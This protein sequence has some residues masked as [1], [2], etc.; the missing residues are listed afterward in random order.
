MIEMSAIL[1]DVAEKA[2]VAVSTVSYVINKTGLHKVSQETQERIR[3][4]A[5]ELGYTPN[6]A[7]RI[8]NGGR[9]GMIGVIMPMQMPLI[10]SEVP[11]D[12]CA[13]LRSKGYQATVGVATTSTERRE[14]INDMISRKVEGMIFFN[15]EKE[16]DDYYGEYQIPILHF[17]G[18]DGE[19]RMALEEGQNL[20]MR[21]L[22]ECHGH[23]RIGCF[24]SLRRF[25]QSKIAGYRKAF[26]EAGLKHSEAWEIDAFDNPCWI[27]ETL[28]KIRKHRLTAMICNNDNYATS[29]IGMLMQNGIR[30]PDDCAVIGY[31][32]DCYG[33]Y[34]AVPLTTVVQ[35]VSLLVERMTQLMLRKIREHILAKLEPEEL[36]PYLHIER[37][38]GCRNSTEPQL[39][40]FCGYSI[41]TREQ[42]GCVL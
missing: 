29:L 31:D 25:N 27:S 24:S 33:P 4:A 2:G 14:V 23:R 42:K 34:L 1:K 11:A 19:I 8:L 13:M 16:I 32:G 36:R 18:M 28:E 21:H 37:S 39:Q 35:P 20:A 30:V 40:T 12:I 3:R 15:C 38:C 22:I 9:S 5:R 17:D 41:D 6:M 26:R 10:Y 7:G